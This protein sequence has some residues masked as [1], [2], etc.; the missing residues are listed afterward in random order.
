[1][2]AVAQPLAGVAV[3]RRRVERSVLRALLI[4]PAC[5]LVAGFIVVPTVVAALDSFAREDHYTLG[6]YVDLLT[7]PPYP[8]VL[9]NTLAIS[10]WVTLVSMA[11]GAPTAAFLATWRTRA[12]TALLTIIGAS[13]WISILVKVYAWQVLLAKRGPVNELL[14]A[15]GVMDEPVPFLFTR[16][17]V[18]ISMIQFMLPYAVILMVTGMRR[19]DWDL[20]VAART[21]GAR[22]PTVFGHVYWPQVRATVVLTALVVFVVSTSFFVAPALLGGPGDVMAGMQMKSDL[23]NRYDSGMAATLG[24]GLMVVL[25]VVSWT[26]IKLSGQSFHRLAHELAS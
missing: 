8:Q 9:W 21:L 10:L 5:L 15:L 17:A 23:V 3:R 25:L 4:A 26:A 14:A 7:S 6:N 16:G 19:I 1:M 24:T 22:A 18:L 12:G 2:T 20:I 13:L 11:L